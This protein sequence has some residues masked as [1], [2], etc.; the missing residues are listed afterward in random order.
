MSTL[1]QLPAELTIYVAA[2]LKAD[3]LTWLD[4]LPADAPTDLRADGRLVSEVDAAGLQCL[5]AL[6][7]SLHSRGRTL[8]LQQPSAV[9]HKACV[10]L[11]AGGLLDP[12]TLEAVS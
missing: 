10:T 2:E 8:L 7:R 12:Q 9:L 11:G 4:G 5:L 3:W 1:L 6:K